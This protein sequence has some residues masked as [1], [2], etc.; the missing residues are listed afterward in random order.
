MRGAL[1]G[2]AVP[3]VHR[4]PRGGP[5]RQGRH[6]AGARGLRAGVLLRVL[7][8]EV[9]ERLHRHR[10][11]ALP[12]GLPAAAELG[13]AARPAPGGPRAALPLRAAHAARGRNHQNLSEVSNPV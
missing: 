4:G 7:H 2:P 3:A 12:Q 11:A 8:S 6:R 5:R 9:P 13:A 1:G 10:A